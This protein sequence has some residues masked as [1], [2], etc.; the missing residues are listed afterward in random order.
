MH[1]TFQL[2]ILSWLAAMS[3]VGALARPSMDAAL[4]A[5][6]FAFGTVLLRVRESWKWAEIFQR[7][8]SV[9]GRATLPEVRDLRVIGDA[10]GVV[11]AWAAVVARKQWP[12][13][14][15]VPERLDVG[16]FV[17]AAT[18]P[19]ATLLLRVVNAARRRARL[20]KLL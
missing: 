4:F 10:L 15:H 13:L 5:A 14:P 3:V 8:S 19:S 1:R 18:V 2:Q 7:R 16:T 20:R 11:V 12:H 17:L 9:F 6:A